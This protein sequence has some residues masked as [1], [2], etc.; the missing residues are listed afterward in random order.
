[1]AV[2]EGEGVSRRAITWFEAVQISDEGMLVHEGLWVVV[3]GGR[4]QLLRAF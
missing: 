1:M 3:R 4:G 2:R